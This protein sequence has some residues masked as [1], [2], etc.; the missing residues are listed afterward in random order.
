M[1]WLLAQTA[2]QA[3]PVP[4]ST[5]WVPALLL[6]LLWI[7]AAAALFGSVKRFWEHQRRT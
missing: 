1:Q 7:F 4:V 3:V 6:T 5:S 2:E